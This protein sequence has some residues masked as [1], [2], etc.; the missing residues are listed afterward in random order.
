M[1][2]RMNRPNSCLSVRFSFSVV[3]LCYSLSVLD[4][5]LQFVCFCWVR[6]SF[7]ST[8]S[9][10]WLGRTSP[11]WPILCRVKC[12]TL[13]RSINQHRAIQYFAGN[14]IYLDCR[15]QSHTSCKANRQIMVK[16]FKRGEKLPLCIHHTIQNMHSACKRI[17]MV[18]NG[19][20]RNGLEMTPFLSPNQQCQC[21]ELKT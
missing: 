5:V 10:E 18:C 20:W 14:S 11:K 13:T 9:R 12:K 21:T 6:F 2:T 3:M 1:H 15:L 8:M 4:F 7:F 19:K 16:N 17:V